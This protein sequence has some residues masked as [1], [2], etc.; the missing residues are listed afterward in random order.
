MKPALLLP[1]TFFIVKT[2]AQ[3]PIPN[4]GFEYWQYTPIW[5]I[6]ADGWWSNNSEVAA[7]NVIPDSTPY[8]GTLALELINNS[9]QGVIT[10]GFPLSAHPT[11]LSGQVKN[12]M[13]TPDMAN[14][15]IVLYYSGI[16]GR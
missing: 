4:P 13:P 6:E 12:Q 5:S 2:F 11:E 3:N 15:S 1:F 10:T 8:A 9:Y 7:W 16:A 14:I